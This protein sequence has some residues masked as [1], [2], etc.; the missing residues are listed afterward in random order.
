MIIVRETRS[1]RGD[2][3]QG[4]A[5]RDAVFSIESI[6]LSSECHAS[7]RPCADRF[8]CGESLEQW[9]GP[10]T[11]RFSALRIRERA[12]PSWFVEAAQGPAGW[13]L[14]EGRIC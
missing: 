4:H 9:F 13:R 10:P 1:S 7:A 11:E 5:Q 6:Q 12:R 8:G 2:L 14:N 3:M